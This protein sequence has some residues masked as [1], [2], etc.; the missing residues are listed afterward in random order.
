MRERMD[1]MNQTII[2]N[3]RKIDTACRSCFLTLDKYHKAVEAFGEEKRRIAAM[4]Y[5]QQEQER[6]VD[7]AA[8]SLNNT[9]QGFYED[10]RRELDVIRQ[11]A[12]EMEALVDI[13]DD[14][15]NALAVV[16]SLGKALPGET[17]I[18]LV[19]RFKG[20]TQA[21]I[22]LK[23]AYE[24]AG[25]QTEPYFK[26]LIFSTSQALDNLDELAHRMTV[27]PGANMMLAVN[28]GSELEKFA[29]SLGVELTSKFRETADVTATLNAQLRA[30]M[31]LSTGA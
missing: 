27:K 3:R 15:Q 16:T 31:G 28:F 13:G 12:G 23:A 21:L 14:L 5:I 19:E 8:E 25:I 9:V 17:R 7:R 1:N 26:G 11:A 29:E 18:R 6:L 2:D 30:A 22:I 20:Q 4:P 10:V 24:V